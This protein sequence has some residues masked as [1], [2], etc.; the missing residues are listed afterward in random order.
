MTAIIRYHANSTALPTTSSTV[1]KI[2]SC[3]DEDLDKLVPHLAMNVT[4]NLA[5]DL[6]ED[7]YA[8]CYYL[9]GNTLIGS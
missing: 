8:A 5:T 6:E 3:N 7:R 9:D 1:T 4:A 2:P